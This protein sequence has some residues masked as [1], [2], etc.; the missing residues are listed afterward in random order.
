LRQKYGPFAW[1]LW[2]ILCV[3]FL[4]LAAMIASLASMD[5]VFLACA[6]FIVLLVVAG[7][8]LMARGREDE[9]PGGPAY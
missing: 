4:V 6:V 9:R 5:P 1:V 3:F 7:T 8:V 2:G